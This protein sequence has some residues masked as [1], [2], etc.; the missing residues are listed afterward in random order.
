M[1]EAMTKAVA[2]V[3]P[4]RIDRTGVFGACSTQELY[5]IQ[6][7]GDVVEVEGG[8]VVQEAS[9]LQ[10]VYIPLGGTLTMTAGE[11]VCVVGSSGV[12]GARTALIGNPPTVSVVAL[13]NATFFVTTT[14]KFLGLLH[15]SPGLGFGI[16]R[17]LAEEPGAV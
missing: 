17:H 1:N 6:R 15:R 14:R 10:W 12:I 16:A 4:R 8:V 13:A 2:R 5:R 7:Q 3:I 9:R 11:Q